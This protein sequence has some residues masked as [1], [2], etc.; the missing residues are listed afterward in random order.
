M[1]TMVFGEEKETVTPSPGSAEFRLSAPKTAAPPQRLARPGL[2]R[3]RRSAKGQPT[4]KVF[5]RA[6]GRGRDSYEAW[7]APRILVVM[8]PGA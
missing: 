3:L 2:Q 8:G 7:R 4:T 6:A 1:A 5:G